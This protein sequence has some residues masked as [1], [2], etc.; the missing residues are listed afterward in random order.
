MWLEI[1]IT[2]ILIALAA[3]ILYKNVK[4]KASGGCDCGTCSAHCTKYNDNHD[5]DTK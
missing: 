5:I 3:F 4:K 2:L 1:L